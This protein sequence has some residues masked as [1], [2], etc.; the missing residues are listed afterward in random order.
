M[1]K[2]Y[3]I[4]TF[5]VAVNFF[6]IQL[7]FADAA[8]KKGTAE[9]SHATSEVKQETVKKSS[10]TEIKNEKTK[11]PAAAK[12]KN[13]TEEEHA[14]VD[15]L[16][17]EKGYEYFSKENYEKASI[18]FHEYISKNSRDVEDYEWAEFFLGVSLNKLGMSHASVDTLSWLVTRKPNTKIVTY[19]LEL[20][21]EITRTKPFDEE[22]LIYRSICDQDYGFVDSELTNFIHYHQGV[23]D[24]KNGFDQWGEN[25]F[26]KIKKG[27]YYF[28]KYKYQIALY[29]I[30]NNDIDKAVKLLSKIVEAPFDGNQLRDSVRK[31]LARLLYEKKEFKAADFLYAQIDTNIIYQS[32]N[33]MERS[34]AQYRL[35]NQEKAMGLLYAFNAP[36]YR[37]YFSPEYFLLKSFI[38]KDVCHY[39]RALNVIHEFR[40]HYKSSLVK[41]YERDDLIENSEMLLSLLGKEKISK[42]WKFLRLLEEEKKQISKFNSPGLQAYLEHIYQLQIDES[43]AELKLLIEEK[44]EEVANNLLEYEEKTDLM[45]YEISLDMYKRVY[46]YHYEEEE[47]DSGEE[48]ESDF[49]K[50]YYA[51]YPFQNE[52]WNDELDNYKVVLENKC[53]SMEEWDIFFK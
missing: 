11:K 21:E 37:N 10:T 19:I 2:I 8:I 50:H 48:A 25:H 17:F 9:K 45:A 12:I 4:I 29:H 24:W 42:V 35:G 28:Y 53:S 39:R 40:D 1:K 27:S 33:L 43:I 32:Q 6:F 52:F 5:A 34:W 15:L 3:R 30:V 46:Q 20:F 51:F 22:S 44:Y 47:K 13:E 7:V 18:Y 38:Y 16:S 14:V 23:F 41:I 36:A 49:I 31:T 26:S